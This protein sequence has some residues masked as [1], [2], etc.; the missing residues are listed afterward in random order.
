MACSILSLDVVAFQ[1][2]ITL[3]G[4]SN[5]FIEKNEEEYEKMAIFSLIF[6]PHN[7][8]AQV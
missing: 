8:I 3:G 2:Y 6:G 1:K 7:L 4:T 5:V